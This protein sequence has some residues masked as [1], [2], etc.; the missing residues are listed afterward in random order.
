MTLTGFEVLLV[1]WTSTDVSVTCR[2]PMSGVVD[3]T[4]TA[5]GN[6]TEAGNAATKLQVGGTTLNAS[7]WMA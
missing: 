6:V 3:E 2:A 7:M 4:E 1:V 5:P